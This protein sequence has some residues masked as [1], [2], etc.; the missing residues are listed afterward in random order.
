MGLQ[1]K[2]LCLLS[3]AGLLTFNV[4]ARTPS[5]V[6]ILSCLAA[7]ATSPSV[8][9]RPIATDKILSLIHI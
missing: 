3:L 8:K 2:R 4:H 1:M 6:A 9:W 5:K 7:Q